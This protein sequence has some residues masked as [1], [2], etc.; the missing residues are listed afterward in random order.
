MPSPIPFAPP[1]MNAVRPA[2]SNDMLSFPWAKVLKSEARRGA[3]AGRRW[4][5][6]PF[7]WVIR[8]ADQATPSATSCSAL[9]IK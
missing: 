3:L 2:T 4:E 1:V 5:R 9:G 7:G 8:D 6:D